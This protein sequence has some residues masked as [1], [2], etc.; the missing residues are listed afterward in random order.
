MTRLFACIMLVATLFTANAYDHMVNGLCYDI[1]EDG[2][3]VSV[4]AER[5]NARPAYTSISGIV[6]IPRMAL[7]DNRP[8][9]VTRIDNSAFIGCTAITAVVIG[10]GVTEIDA[11]AF[12]GCS[13]LAS[14]TFGRAVTTIGF[15]SFYNCRALTAIDLPSAVT[16]IDQE[17]FSECSAL[18][19]ATMPSSLTTIGYG[20]FAYCSKLETITGGENVVKVGRDALSDTKWFKTQPDGIVYFGKVALGISGNFPETVNIKEGTVSIADY[21]LH[22]DYVYN[23]NFPSTLKEIGSNSFEA[24]RNLNNVTFPA[25]LEIIGDKAFDN[26]QKFTEVVIPDNVKTIGGNAF[27]RNSN[28][29]ELIIGKSVTSIGRNAFT[30]CASLQKIYSYPNPDNV[31]LGNNAFSYVPTSTC[32]LHVMNEYLGKYQTANQWKAFMPNIVGDLSENAAV[33]GDI[34]GDG[35]VDVDDMNIIINIIVGK[36]NVANFSEVADVNGSGVVDVDDMNIIINIIV[37]KAL[38]TDAA[39]VDGQGK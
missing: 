21:F 39:N 20:A 5:R 25:G 16:V 7:I 11:Y 14:V 15:G 19:S 27:S 35:V 26:A 18:T 1:N 17:A 2:N 30:S 34:N 33:K 13:N 8:Y 23:V 10:D 36:A 32:V 29:V 4:V 12:K 28:L 22:T 37:G 38:A 6:N 24:C 3:T 31:T 9:T